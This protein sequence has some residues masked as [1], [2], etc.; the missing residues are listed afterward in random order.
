MDAV[1]AS[2]NPEV[3]EFTVAYNASLVPN[4][5]DFKPLNNNDLTNLKKFGMGT[6][7]IRIS[8]NGTKDYKD[9]NVTA[10]VTMNDS[11]TES[12]VAINESASFTYNMNGSVMKQAIFDNVIDWNNAVLPAR[13]TLSVDN[14]EMTYKALPKQLDDIVARVGGALDLSVITDALK[15]S[16]PIEGMTV[17]ISDVPAIGGILGSLLGDIQ[18]LEY[19]SI[20][21]GTQLIQISY[22]GNPE[23]RPSSVETTVNIRKANVSVNVQW[24]NIRA[25][26]PMPANFITTNPADD[27][28]V[29]TIYTGI[30]SNVSLGIYL[31][32]PDS[33]TDNGLI[34]V[35]DPIVEGILGKTLTQMMNDG[36]S[37][38]EL[39]Q[40]FRAQEL[41]NFLNGLGVDTGALGQ[42]LNILDATAGIVDGIRVSFGT[43]SRAGLYSAI[44]VTENK[45][46]NVGVG[47]GTILVR[48]NTSGVKLNWNQ[49]I[50]GSMT[51]A[52][53]QEFDFGVTLSVDG[54]VTV[55]QS[56]VHYLYSGLTSKLRIYSSTTTPPTEPGSYV[57]TV[58]T[59]GGDYL[60][61]PIT[62]TF[63]I[64][65]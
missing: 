15:M 57:V 13:E 63:R 40:L 52:Q 5:K 21:A 38:G 28:N 59:L 34:K 3:T 45:N 43:P 51:S 17:S 1:I 25:G 26:Q 41:L 18:M 62:R 36:L 39:R 27:F 9:G 32:L 60:A 16:V 33:F 47:Y 12:V 65:K 46:Y 44:A 4:L 55:N 48:L 8:W 58:V 14:F 11:R 49:G 19:P 56:S 35:I 64:T 6:W 53:A 42:I 2:T 61:A 50:S 20:G 22:K 7:E 54:D 23:Y 30:T 10:T 24:T 29:Y 31:D 37:V